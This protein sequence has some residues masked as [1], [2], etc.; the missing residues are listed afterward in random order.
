MNRAFLGITLFIVG[1]GCIIFA[2]FKISTYDFQYASE[3]ISLLSW[4]SNALPPQATDFSYLFWNFYVVLGSVISG[5]ILMPVGLI[6]LFRA[7]PKS[8]VREIAQTS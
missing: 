8:Q 2:G 6:T 3:M 4:H 7:N 1:L 5:I